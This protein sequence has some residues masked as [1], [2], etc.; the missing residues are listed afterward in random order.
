MVRLNNL[1]L[2]ANDLEGEIPE[3]LSGLVTL[4]HLSLVEG[5]QSEQNGRDVV[6]RLGPM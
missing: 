2:D 6:A 3:E 5:L 4:E 1:I